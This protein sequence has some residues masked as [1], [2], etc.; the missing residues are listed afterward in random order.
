M[1]TETL[2]AGQLMMDLDL[3]A[4]RVLDNTTSTAGVPTLATSWLS[5]GYHAFA[6]V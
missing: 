2:L 4:P 5:V 6:T 3:A 1:V